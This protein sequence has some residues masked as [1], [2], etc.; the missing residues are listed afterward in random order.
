MHMNPHTSTSYLLD[1]ARHT[2]VNYKLLVF[3]A[4]RTAIKFKLTAV[5]IMIFKLTN[6]KKVLSKERFKCKMGK[7]CVVNSTTLV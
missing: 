2:M 1:R 7:F 4:C 5:V 6:I 3:W